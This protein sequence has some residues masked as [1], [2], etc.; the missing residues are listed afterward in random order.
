M[1]QSVLLIINVYFYHS[2]IYHIAKLY[3]CY[4]IFVTYALVF[5]VPLDFM[6]PPLFRRL[7]IDKNKQPKR[8]FLLQT[9]F[10]S[11]LV[12]ITGRNNFAA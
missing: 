8:A 12:L 3:L 6:E 11:V 9:V 7:K 4:A 5:Y 2:R 1:A 10:R